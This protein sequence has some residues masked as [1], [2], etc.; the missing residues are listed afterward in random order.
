MQETGPTVYNP[1]P[2]RPERLTICRYNY[3]CVHGLINEG[4]ETKQQDGIYKPAAM[5]TTTI[6]AKKVSAGNPD[7][8][9]I[10]RIEMFIP[11]VCSL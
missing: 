8:S 5:K 1:Y 11:V 10:T 3:N 7:L 2:R 9:K 4:N 6:N